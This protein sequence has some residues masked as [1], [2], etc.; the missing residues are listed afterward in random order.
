[1]PELPEVE[2]V[3]RGLM[4][5]IIGEEIAKV[6]LYYDKIV[7]NAD[8][9]KFAAD[10][11]G[12]VFQNVLRRGKFLIFQTDHYDL[13]SHL[14]MEGKYAL[15]DGVD[16][17][18][19]HVHVV[20]EFESGKSL[21]YQD[22][23]K[24][25]R[26][27][28]LPRDTA[29]HTYKGIIQ[30]GPE[31]TPETF[32]ATT[33]YNELHKNHAV[34]KPLLLNQKIVV[35]LG[36][37]YVDE[38]LWKS[39]INPSLKASDI[40][41]RHSNTLHKATI[42]TLEEAIQ[43]GGTTIRSYINADGQTG[44]HQ[45]HL[46]VYGQK[47]QPCPRCKTPIDKYKLAGRSTHFCPKCQPLPDYKV[48][49]IGITGGIATGKSTASLYLTSQG[50]TVIDADK[51]AHQI[52]EL[53]EIIERL[54]QSFGPTI[55]TE[56]GL[57]DR[58]KLGAIAFV[59]EK[60]I[61]KLNA[62]T[63]PLIRKTILEEIAKEKQTQI[64]EG[65]KNKIIFVDIPLLFEMN[66]EKEF[67]KIIVLSTDEKTQITRI[68]Q[69]DNITKKQAQDIINRQL[70]LATKAAKADYVIDTTGLEAQTQA[71]LKNTLKEIL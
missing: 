53:P 52:L 9:G 71:Q 59:S 58:K 43:H 12:E 15:V 10:L 32:D 16:P 6:S 48:S 27:M 28:L 66:Y 42:E 23:R 49:V 68:K 55:L 60:E 64:Q 30:L 41:R 65:K 22:V 54:E 4:K 21:Q 7:E 46:N 34:I 3:R 13:V 63:Q 61:A 31:P 19:K 45:N 56:Q 51:I 35:G 39:K 29:L 67:D 37:I 38:V 24:F 44:E 20:F 25:G 8:K 57:I 5:L 1:M 40:D 36:N 18:N 70:P 17:Q 2:T 11:E 47:G 33:F 62:I 26:M 14:R 50:Y 69:R